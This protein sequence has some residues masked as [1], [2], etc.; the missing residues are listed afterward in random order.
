MTIS[1]PDAVFGLGIIALAVM[2]YMAFFKFPKL[3]KKNK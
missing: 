1:Y 3:K 2:V